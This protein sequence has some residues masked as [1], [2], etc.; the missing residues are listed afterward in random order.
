M[1]VPAVVGEDGADIAVVVDCGFLWGGALPCCGRMV[2]EEKEECDGRH[3]V[4]HGSGGPV[5]DGQRCV[6][7]LGGKACAEDSG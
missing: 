6:L 3:G 5:L 7:G 2:E 1:A 4:V